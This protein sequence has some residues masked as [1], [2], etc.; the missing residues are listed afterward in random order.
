MRVFNAPCN[1][2]FKTWTEPKHFARWL[3]PKDCTT[4]SCEMDVRL[5]GVYRACI[6]SPEGTDHWMQ[7][8]YHEIVEPEWLVFTFAWE[9]K[10]LVTVFCRASWHK[11]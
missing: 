3:G 8:V 11:P 6:R 4:T 9:D 5:G 10:D 7:G 1:L 2:V